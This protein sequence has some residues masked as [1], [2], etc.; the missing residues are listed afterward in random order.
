MRTSPRWTSIRAKLTAAVVGISLASAA[1][2][3]VFF[4]PRLERLAR[5]ALISKGTGVAEVL[6]Y[7]LVAPLEFDDLRGILEAISSVR[8]DEGVEMVEVCGLDGPLLE[9]SGDLAPYVIADGMRSQETRVLDHGPRLIITV[10]ALSALLSLFAAVLPS[11]ALAHTRSVS[12]STWEIGAESTRVSVRTKLLELSR[13]GPEILPPDS[14]TNA[15]Q[16]GM[17]EQL[18]RQFADDLVLVADRHRCTIRALP[19]RKTDEPGWIRVHWQIDCPRGAESLAIRSRFLL[20]V[21]PSHMHFARVRFDEKPDQVFESVLTEA[22]PEFELLGS[23]EDTSDGSNT[24]QIGSR[25]I[26]YL[27]LGV[28]HILTGWDHLAFV[29]GLLLLASRFG[30]VARL[31]TGFTLAHSLTLALAVQG[32]VHPHAAAVEAIIALSVALVAIEKGWLLSDRNRSVPIA[33]LAG[34]TLLGLTSFL[35]WTS[36]PVVT[37]VGL[38]IF[39]ACYFTLATRSRS[40]WLRFCLTFAFGLVHGFGFAGILV[41]MTLPT[42]RLVPAL[43]GFNLGVEI[44]QIGVVLLLWPLL[45]MGARFSSAPTNRLVGELSAAALSGLGLYWLVERAFAP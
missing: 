33:V 44:G 30:E 25:L 8:R 3:V 13:L 17:S 18:A 27:A 37:I 26:D 11:T 45:A 10:S 42:D 22:S 15:G 29:F 28:D 19:K 31:I 12:Y 6:A 41:E 4:P 14:I 9:V 43:V 40:E 20:S 36:L 39:T 1:V 35:G 16:P 21:A 23:R 7:N 38:L 24:A 34:I 32:L 5:A 2:I